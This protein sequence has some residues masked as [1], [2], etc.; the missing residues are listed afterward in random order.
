VAPASAGETP[1]EL[2]DRVANALQ[3]RSNG[4]AAYLVLTRSQLDYEHLMG[5]LPWGSVR[6]LESGAQQ[7]PRFRLLY[8]NPDAMVFELTEAR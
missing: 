8:E 4:A 1:V 6:D 2:A 5:T 3:E 7:T